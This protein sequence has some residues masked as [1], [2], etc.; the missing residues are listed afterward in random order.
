MHVVAAVDLGASSGRVVA[1]LIDDDGIHIEEIHRF[2][3]G[4]VACDGHLR[5]DIERLRDEVFVG[6]RALAERHPEVESIGIDTWAVDYALLDGEGRLLDGPIAYRD[7]RTTSAI[8]AIHA[9]IDR[10]ELF[11]IAGVQ[12]LPFNTIYQL[13]SERSV[14]RWD[15]VAHI[16]LLPDLLAYWLT[17]R[18]A[19][20]ATNA[21]TT[22]LVDVRS[23]E[24]SNRLLD[25]LELPA[26]RLP[27]IEPA[28]SVRGTLTPEVA[29]RLGMSAEVTVI[30]VGS[31]D[32]ASAVAAVPATTPDFAYVS[33][34][35]WSLV[36]LELETPNVSDAAFDANF[37]NEVGVDGTIRFLRNVGGLWLLQESMREWAERGIDIELAALTD[38]AGGVEDAP[39]F[40]VDD[41][42][43]IEPGDMPSRIAAAVGD[44]AIADDHPRLARS[45]FDS[46][47]TAYGTVIDAATSITQRSVDVVH[48]VGGGAHNELL[49]QLAADRCGIPVIAGPVEA[50][51]LGNV[52]IQARSIGAAPNSLADLRRIGA[53]STRTYVPQTQEGLAR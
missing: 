20:E 14:R 9:R 18:L 41:P 11:E 15:E 25:L 2:P 48:V 40:D 23:G 36:G 47:A 12:F 17:G 24:W 49:C 30:A 7:G 42:T 50:T 37:T 43:F 34:G 31:H 1:G 32:T 27:P 5:W 51:A 39:I 13:Q 45:I 28:G 16:V 22:G 4:V 44:S 53:A 3:N 6:L 29:D 35:T 33:S 38:A 10:R 8:N 46:L 52:M 19:T 21:S 26:D